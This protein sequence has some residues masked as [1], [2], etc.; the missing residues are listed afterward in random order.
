MWVLILLAV[1]SALGAEARLFLHA[2]AAQKPKPL[3]VACEEKVKQSANRAAMEEIA[4]CDKPKGFYPAA[5]VALRLKEERWAE[6][7]V[8][9]V[10][11]QCGGFTDDCAKQF[12]P[13]A[14]MQMR[15]AGAAVSDSCGAEMD[16]M[17]AD[18]QHR[19][20]V[21]KCEEERGL[22]DKLVAHLKQGHIEDALVE[23]ETGLDKCVG[24]DGKLCAWQIAPPVV[25]QVIGAMIQHQQQQEQ[26]P[27]QGDMGPL[28]VAVHPKEQMLN[29]AAILLDFPP[30]S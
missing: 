10:L 12:A 20:K 28:L 3:S 13:A 8:T 7:N 27:Q 26:L 11:T 16:A 14:V 24:F 9:E 2:P 29:L 30:I 23:A 18:E 25:R 1:S 19:A 5:V 17:G 21:Q 4:A 6:K 15:F 22:T